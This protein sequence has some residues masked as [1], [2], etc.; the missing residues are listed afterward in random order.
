M[1]HI[2]VDLELDQ[3]V[4]TRGR[5]F[6]WTFENVDEHK[7]LVNFPAGDLFF[8]ISTHGEHNG[9]GH[10]DQQGSTGGTYRISDGTNTSSALTFDASEAVVK[11]AIEDLPT[12]G[13]GNVNVTGSY[14]PQWICVTTWTSAMALSAGVVDAFNAAVTGAFGALDFIS[15]GL[16]VWLEGHYE[17]TAYI[18]KLTFKGTLLETELVNFVMGT[19]SSIIAALNSALEAV[20]YFTG[21]ISNTSVFY[22]PLRHFDYEFVN[23]KALTP[24]PA[25]SIV[26][27]G[28]TGFDQKMSATQDAPGRS[29]FTIWPFIIDGPTASLKVESE[30]ADAI[31]DRTKWQLVFLPQGEPAGGDAIARGVV[32]VQAER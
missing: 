3:L 4:L 31:P 8:E 14:T 22:A 20:E 13:A 7:E 29:P 17:S 2:G 1:A 19:I 32:K 6:K 12:V 25:L 16:G 26:S 23:D 24:M 28:L 10:F 27:S 30:D 18:F 9:R 11:Q 5:D 21:Q 15:G